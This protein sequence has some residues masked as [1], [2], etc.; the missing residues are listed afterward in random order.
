MF[1]RKYRNIHSGQDLREEGPGLQAYKPAGVGLLVSQLSNLE[2]DAWVAR[3]D[4]VEQF[5]TVLTDE[6]FQVVARHIVPL[7]AI[8][9]EV[10]QNGQTG[11]IITL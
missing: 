8:V 11:F 6:R 1:V 5:V 7:D 2:T 3:A 10:V 9:V 4:E